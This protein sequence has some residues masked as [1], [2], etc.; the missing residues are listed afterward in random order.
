LPVPAPA[1][2]GPAVPRSGVFPEG[3][4]GAEDVLSHPHLLWVQEH[5]RH[6]GQ[7]AQT[8][9]EP[10]LHLAQVRRRPWWR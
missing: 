1:M 4:A 9:S 8:V 6:L 5:L 7:S 10:A 3:A 2:V